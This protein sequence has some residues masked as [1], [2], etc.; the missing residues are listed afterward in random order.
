MLRAK[1]SDEHIKLKSM[2][3]MALHESGYL[4]AYEECFCDIVAFEPDRGL[5]YGV[6]IE[7]ST[8]NALRNIVRNFKSDCDYVVSVAPNCKTASA[9]EQKI[10]HLP[11]QIQS[12]VKVLTTDELLKLLRANKSLLHLFIFHNGPNYT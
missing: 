3:G 8:K 5:T 9:L 6:E 11:E 2:I 12:K 4:I 7:R 1:E 10:G